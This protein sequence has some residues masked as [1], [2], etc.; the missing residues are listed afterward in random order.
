L[1]QSALFWTE[2][3]LEEA[4]E[5]WT[6]GNAMAQQRPSAGVYE[7]DRYRYALLRQVLDEA[8]VAG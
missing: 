3:R 7:Y 6:K 4:R 8:P 1:A 5:A 2:N